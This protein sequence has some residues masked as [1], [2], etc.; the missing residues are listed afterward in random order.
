MV[1]PSSIPIPP[2]DAL[3]AF[4]DKFGAVFV[5]EMRQG[6][7]AHRFV[8]PF[9]TLHALA[10]LAVVGQ[11]AFTFFAELDNSPALYGLQSFFDG[12]LERSF[13]TLLWFFVGIVM[14][15]TGINALQAE[16]NHERNIDLLLMSGLSRWQIIRGKWLVLCSLSFL[17]LISMLP[18][19]LTLY[20]S[21]GI[22]LIGQV[23][24]MFKLWLFNGLM[25]AATLASSAYR[26]LVMR[27]LLIGLIFFSS[28]LSFLLTLI[29][30]HIGIITGW[31]WLD[32]GSSLLNHLLLVLLY[33][34][35]SL[36][37]GRS[38]LRIYDKPTDPPHTGLLIILIIF[39]PVA[40]ALFRLI[41]G[42]IGMT[43][44]LIA[45]AAI[46][47]SIDPMGKKRD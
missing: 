15:L 18:Y 32:R 11:L 43:L 24:E 22:D 30:T 38:S 2:D 44:A 47:L 36:Q 40:L 42:P 20:F 39:T 35:Y 33:L 7:R 8:A 31:H 45:A 4:S 27:L 5:K 26:H 23:K 21:G 1:K 17:I 19:M 16:L 37:L 12:M 34:A 41:G 9:L 46:T 13:L 3:D 28:L 25:C 14:P 29:P 6:L 10:F